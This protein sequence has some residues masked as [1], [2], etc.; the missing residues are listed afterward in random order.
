VPIL[1]SVGV[2][3][4]IHG[5]KAS[6]VPVGDNWGRSCI[7]CERCEKRGHCE[8]HYHMVLLF[9]SMSTLS[10]F[11]SMFLVR[12]NPNVTRWHIPSHQP[13]VLVS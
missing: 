9:L 5:L 8:L 11:D 4:G 10:R 3:F 12:Q 13:C 2:S 6:F 1:H 7:L